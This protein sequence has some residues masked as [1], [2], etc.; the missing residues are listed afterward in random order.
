MRG[1]KVLQ[2]LLVGEKLVF[3]DPWFSSAV[4]YNTVGSSSLHLSISCDCIISS[5]VAPFEL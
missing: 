5:E 1:L 3:L 4:I 2:I